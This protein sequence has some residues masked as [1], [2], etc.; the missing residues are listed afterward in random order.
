MFR[1]IRKMLLA[2]C[3]LVILIPGKTWAMQTPA[4]QFAC[5]EK[6]GI[7]AL[8]LFEYD[9]NDFKELYGD[10]ELA[11]RLWKE[12]NVLLYTNGTYVPFECTIGE[13]H[14]KTETMVEVVEQDHCEGLEA[15]YT[16]IWLNNHLVFDGS[17]FSECFFQTYVSDIY[18]ASGGMRIRGGSVHET[19][20]PDWKEHKYVGRIFPYQLGTQARK[21]L[22]TTNATIFN[23]GQKALSIKNNDDWE[24]YFDSKIIRGIDYWFILTGYESK[25]MWEA[26][27]ADL[28]ED[29]RPD[30][31]ATYHSGADLTKEQVDHLF[32]FMLRLNGKIVRKEYAEIWGKLNPNER[33]VIEDIFFDTAFMPTKEYGLQNPYAGK[34]TRLFD[35][36]KRYVEAQEKGDEKEATK[37]LNNAR[38]EI[39]YNSNRLLFI[40]PEE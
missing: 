15:S 23:E 24:N 40:Y 39:K 28:S 12:D 18:F 9:T 11:A 14:I 4:I 6:E 25:P 21:H 36:M 2:I 31:N 16:K 34:H 37:H 13:N 22:P 27:F 19:Y 17:L 38:W 1:N 30:F 3:F 5:M 10:P 8:L 26:A 20:T 35:N 32:D 33:I 29:K 7:F